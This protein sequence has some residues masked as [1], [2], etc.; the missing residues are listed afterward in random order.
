[1]KVGVFSTQPYDREPLLAANAGHGHE[2][3]FIEARLSLDTV[4]LA[5]PFDAVIVFVND[6][7]P[8]AVLTRLAAGK[9]RLVA[10][11]CAA[12]GSTTW[13]WR[14]RRSSGSPSR[15]SPPILLMLSPN[16]PWV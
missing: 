2:L 9:T 8:R 12:R 7:L 4:D 5:A 16:T 15:A 11:R 1:M 3:V 14:L 6:A 10:L 13:P